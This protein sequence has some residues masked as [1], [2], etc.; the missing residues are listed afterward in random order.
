MTQERAVSGQASQ[1][2]PNPTTL[3]ATYYTLLGLPPSA[4]IQEIRRSY[5]ELSKLYHP[6]TT[7]LPSAIATTKFQ[8]LNEA[9]ATLSS[10]ERRLVYDQK[11]GYSRFTVIQ[12]PADLNRPVGTTRPV[13]SSAYLDPTDRPLSAG[14][15]FA[16]FILALTFLACLILA[17]TIGL[18]RGDTVL[19][20]L[21][22]PPA[23]VL[24]SPSP[25]PSPPLP[26]AVVSTS[27]AAQKKA[28]TPSP[29]PPFPA[30]TST[31]SESIEG[32]ASQP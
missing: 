30:V 2:V 21:P 3:D 11:N 16:L 14:E 17:F 12:A 8:Q 13:S 5:R 1:N 18:T 6:D 23:T 7:I 22:L 31:A 24:E 27:T 32:A 10:A 9:Y 28:T 15:I 26:A 19:Q 20:H 25:L 4:S 29:L